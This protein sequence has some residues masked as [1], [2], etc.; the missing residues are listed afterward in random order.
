MEPTCPRCRRQMKIEW[1]A[2]PNGGEWF[3]CGPCDIRLPITYRGTR[4]TT[5]MAIQRDVRT[6]GKKNGTDT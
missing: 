2:G 6:P 4:S 5:D 3:E 1:D